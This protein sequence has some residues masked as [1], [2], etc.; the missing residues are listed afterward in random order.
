MGAYM[1][2]EAASWQP[3]VTQEQSCRFIAPRTDNPPAPVTYSG[4]ATTVS[5]RVTA[6]AVSNSCGQNVCRVWVGAAGGGIWTTDNGLAAVP[7]WHSSSSGL[8]SNAIG[9]IALDPN[10]STGATLYVG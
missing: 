7:T 2:F 4:R 6:I 1:L 5:G 9:S 8:A 10:D 3:G